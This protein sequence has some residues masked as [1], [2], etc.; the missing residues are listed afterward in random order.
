MWRTMCHLQEFTALVRKDIVLLG[1]PDTRDE[2]WNKAPE[3]F[4]AIGRDDSDFAPKVAEDLKEAGASV[5]L[6]QGH[7]S[8]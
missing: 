6:D 2:L 5:W 3:R 7:R 8:W 4:S 1:I